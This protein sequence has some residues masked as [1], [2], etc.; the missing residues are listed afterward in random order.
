MLNERET[1]T[2]EI[3]ETWQRVGDG[4]AQ[5]GGKFF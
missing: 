5:D 4:M 2:H 1:G 3:F